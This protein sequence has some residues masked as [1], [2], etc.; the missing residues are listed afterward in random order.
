MMKFSFVFLMLFLSIQSVSAQH[1]TARNFNLQKAAVPPDNTTDTIR[2]VDTLAPASIPATGNVAEN[3]SK[4][5]TS[6]VDAMINTDNGRKKT[7]EALSGL[8]NGKFRKDTTKLWNAGGAFSINAS[9][10][11]LDN[12][13]GGGTNSFSAVSSLNLYAD[14]LNKKTSWNNTLNIQYGYLNASSNKI[15]G[16]KNVDLVDFISMYGHQFSPKFD[17]SNLGRIR[18]QISKS[19]VYEKN[20][21]TEQDERKG[22]TSRFFA[23][24]YVTLAPG[25]NY[26]PVKGLSIFVSPIA[27]RGVFVMD[28]SLSKAGAFGVDPGEMFKFQFGAYA[29]LTAKFNI[30]KNIFYASNLE[31]YSNYLYNPEN[32]YVFMTNTL[33]AKITKVIALNV[34]YNLAYDDLYRPIQDRGPKLQTQAIYGLGLMVNF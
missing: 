28:D 4:A 32:I 24:A 14:Y 15:G 6:T 18:T 29:N 23:P 9:Q 3:A 27:V 16:R 31:L 34:N 33:T 1:D 2:P 5:N 20:K 8:V 11:T 25:I 21:E 19:Y 30:T 13:S 22:Y 7:K 12:W 17:F 26:R 10:T